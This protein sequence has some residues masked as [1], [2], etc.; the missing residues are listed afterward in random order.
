MSIIIFTGA[1]HSGKTTALLDWCKRQKD[2]AGILM[3]DIN[4]RRTILD[5]VTKEYTDIECDDPVAANEKLVKV[6]RFHFYE[7]VFERF[8]S[9][10]P[11]M[12]FSE[13]EWLVI[14][15][16]GKLELQEK[17]FYPAIKEVIESVE[18]KGSKT[19]LILVFREGIC[20]ELISF[21]KIKKY[22]IVSQ[23]ER[24]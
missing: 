23:L 2:I 11:K 14:D 5:L 4:G 13:P 9:I 22:T 10:I 19:K 6:G 15:E 21:F 12:L 8:N 20:D 7:A 1:V 3:P 16:A 17:G 24:L 18:K